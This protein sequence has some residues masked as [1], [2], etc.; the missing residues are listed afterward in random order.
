MDIKTHRDKLYI[1]D[2]DGNEV[3]LTVQDVADLVGY[4]RIHMRGGL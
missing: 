1:V 2:Q 3:R 4:L